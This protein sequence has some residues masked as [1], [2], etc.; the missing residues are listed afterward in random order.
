MAKLTRSDWTLIGLIGVLATVEAV[1]LLTDNGL[2]TSVRLRQIAYDYAGF[3]PG[4]LG[5]WTPNYG[6][7]PWLMFLTYGFL[8]T[9][10]MHLIVN[11]IT[12]WSVGRPVMERVGPLGFGLLYGAALLGGAIGYALLAT[13]PSPMVGASGALFGLVGGLLAWAYVDRYTFNQGLWPVAQAVGLLVLLNLVIWWAMDG[14]LAWQTHLGGF[15]VGWV[16]ATVIDPRPR[17]PDPD[18]S[19]SDDDHPKPRP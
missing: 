10:P 6:S 18:P 12:L 11:S 4:L 5:S 9:G 16:M 3:W 2:M 13:Q 8:H 19:R 1:L 17:T 7:Q 15:L 14:R